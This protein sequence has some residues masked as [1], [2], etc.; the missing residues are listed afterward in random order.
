M[1]WLK[2]KESGIILYVHIVPNA[3]KSEI[4]GE[5]SGRLKIKISSPPVDG[6]ANKE[7][8]KFF[9]KLLN[10]SKSKIE[11]ISGEKSKDKAIF[12]KDIE[13]NKFEKILG[14]V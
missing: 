6:A 11:I 4:I 8:K 12:F 7:I 13:K 3:K 9:S 1:E 5:Y 14:G 2:E 10:L